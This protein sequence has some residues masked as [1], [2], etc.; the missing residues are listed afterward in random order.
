[1]LLHCRIKVLADPYDQIDLV[2]SQARAA[3]FTISQY[4]FSKFDLV[5]SFRPDRLGHRQV[6][7]LANHGKLDGIDGCLQ[8]GLRKDHRHHWQYL[9]GI[10]IPRR[11]IL[12]GV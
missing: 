11:K 6:E 12:V 2:S 7:G 3:Y 8:Q 10:T 4:V 1:M 5:F 9:G